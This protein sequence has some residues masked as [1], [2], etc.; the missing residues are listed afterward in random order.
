MAGKAEYFCESPV[1]ELN[2]EVQNYINI[3]IYI[4]VQY[5]F[6]LNCQITTFA[7]QTKKLNQE[8]PSMT[9]LVSTENFVDL[10]RMFVNRDTLPSF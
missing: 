1:H 9:L 8:G 2:V 4:I 7:K 6:L 3:Y 5:I 10:I